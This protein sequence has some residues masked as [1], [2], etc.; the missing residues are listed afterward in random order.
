MNTEQQ[1][2]KEAQRIF[3]VYENTKTQSD[4]ILGVNK[5]DFSYELLWILINL[6]VDNT[7]GEFLESME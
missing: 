4:F 3:A 5:I 7:A 2:L 1:I 6:A